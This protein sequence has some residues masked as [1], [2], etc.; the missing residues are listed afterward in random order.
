MVLMVP[1][2]E[3]EKAIILTAYSLN[4]YS[5]RMMPYFSVPLHCHSGN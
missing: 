5:V 4:N 2:F 3:Y 1:L